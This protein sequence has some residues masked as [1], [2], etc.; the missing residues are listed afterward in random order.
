MNY[1]SL[2]AKKQEVNRAKFL[3]R[4]SVIKTVFFDL[5]VDFIVAIKSSIFSKKPTKICQNLSV[6]FK[7]TQKTSI[8]LED[9][10]KFLWLL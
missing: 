1:E 4:T 2:S 6:G 3:I 10:V 5:T 9:F 8:Q 7:F